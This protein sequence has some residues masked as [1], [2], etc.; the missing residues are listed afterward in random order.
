MADPQSL[1]GQVVSGNE[2]SENNDGSLGSYE[3]P[4]DPCPSVK[5]KRSSDPQDE[6]YVPEE[7]V[8]EH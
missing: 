2:E 1:V 5:R 7:E 4:S 3:S 6:N 8:Y